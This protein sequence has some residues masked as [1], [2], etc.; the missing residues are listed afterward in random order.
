MRELKNSSIDWQNGKGTEVIVA[1]E[2][3]YAME[4]LDDLLLEVI[5]ETLKQVFREEGTAAIYDYL[6]S[7]CRLKREEIAGKTEVFS[8]CLE[9]LLSSAA[10]VI[11]KLILKNLYHKLKSKFKEKKGYEFSDYVKKLSES[12]VVEA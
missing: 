4:T 12:A 6:E 3:L 10:S 2:Q 11:E 8:A 9:R 1:T 5:D 7:K